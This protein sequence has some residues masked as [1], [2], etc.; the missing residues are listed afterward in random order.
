MKKSTKI[1]IIVGAVLLA[2]IILL[3]AT[4]N[5]MVSKEESVQTK[6]SDVKVQ[7]Q[8]RADLTKNLVETVKGYAEYEQSTLMAV[9]E[10]RT[11]V[12]KAT[13][14]DELDAADRQLTSAINVMVEAYPDLKASDAYTSFM[15]SY[16]GTENRV[17]Y[18]RKESNEAI[19]AY[20]A[21]IK[22]FPNNIFAGIFGFDTYE[23]FENEPGTESA[24]DVDF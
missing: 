13:T 12:S 7:L 14:P 5:G 19:R 21:S 6:I 22:R 8:R 18:A 4:Y 3:V 17:A 23:Y 11:A 1:L 16:T 9:T 2:L 20:N 15:D 24:P 10:A